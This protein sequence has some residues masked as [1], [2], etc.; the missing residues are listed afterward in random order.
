RTLAAGEKIGHG[1]VGGDHQLLDQA[2][3]CRLGLR[4]RA[5]HAALAVELEIDLRRLDAKRAVPEAAVPH[6]CRQAGGAPERRD[7]IRCLIPPFRL[8]T[9]YPRAAADD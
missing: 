9:P 2:M 8:R 1:L 7:Y 3:R 4:P 5:S 6:R